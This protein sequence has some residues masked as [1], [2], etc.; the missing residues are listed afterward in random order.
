M[1]LFPLS[2]VNGRDVM[3]VLSIQSGPRVGQI[4]N[5]LLDLV[6]EKAEHNQK[7]KLIQI[8]EE[9]KER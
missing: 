1:K 3:D 9:I 2:G 6:I 7:Y 5:Q 8:L 4:V